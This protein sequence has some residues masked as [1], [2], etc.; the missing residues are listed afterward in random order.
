MKK[1]NVKLVLLLQLVVL[2]VAFMWIKITNMGARSSL[3]YF[4]DSPT[5]ISLLLF[6]VPGL[7]ALGEG[8]DFLNALSVGQK[9][10][11]LLE[12]K[13]ILEAVKTCQKLVLLSG[14]F[15]MVITFMSIFMFSDLE[16]AYIW[17][18]PVL[19]IWSLPALYVIIAE[20]FLMPL[21]INTQKTINEAMDLDEEELNLNE[22]K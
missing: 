20:Y 19:Q 12:L 21:S 9:E 5:L 6:T 4:I 22:E 10:Y 11:R 15:D 16:T 3:I 1:K 17:L 14:L 18:G 13:N 2:V 7:I 8:K